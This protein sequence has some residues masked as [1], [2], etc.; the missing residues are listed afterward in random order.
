MSG[1]FSIWTQLK[2]IVA[3]ALLLLAILIFGVVLPNHDQLSSTAPEETTINLQNLNISLI[4]QEKSAHQQQQQLIILSNT[5]DPVN[6]QRKDA[7]LQL[8]HSLW[9]AVVEEERELLASQNSSSSNGDQNRQQN[10]HHLSAVELNEKRGNLN[11]TLTLSL[12]TLWVAGLEEQFNQTWSRLFENSTYHLASSPKYLEA[13]KVSEAVTDLLGSLL[14]CHALTG[15][16]QFLKAAQ[17]VASSL[18][19]A[20]DNQ[21]G[22]I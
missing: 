3:A 1:K 15:N 14:S 13:L 21:T 18:E 10:H 19:P 16:A 4:L 8:I 22:K 6:E 7:V 20:Y 12:S 2:L 9:S 11:R 17:A 5:T